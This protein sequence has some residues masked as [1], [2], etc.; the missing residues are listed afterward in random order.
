MQER[1]RRVRTGLQPGEALTAIWRPARVH[2]GFIL[3]HENQ[4]RLAGWTR[5]GGGRPN[6]TFLDT[7]PRRDRYRDRQH[8]GDDEQCLQEQPTSMVCFAVH[9]KA[10]RRNW[11]Q[12]RILVRALLCCAP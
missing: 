12:L 6:E 2:R 10:P 3:K 11:P 4:A 7:P 1:G 5:N 9:P 8:V